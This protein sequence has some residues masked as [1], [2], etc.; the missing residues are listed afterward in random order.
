L[1]ASYESGENLNG[2][3]LLSDN[4]LLGFPGKKPGYIQ[5]IELSR[6]ENSNSAIIPAHNSA[7]SCLAMSPDGKLVASTS[8][9]GTLVRVFDCDSG[10]L[11]HELRRGADQA[12]IWT[13]N[14][15]HDSRKLCAGSDKGTIHIFNLDSSSAAKEDSSA[16]S[17][18]ATVPSTYAFTLSQTIN[19]LSQSIFYQRFFAKV[20]F[21]CME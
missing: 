7:L 21:V 12:E 18:K 2:L 11:L 4:G 5:L 13:L 20:L 10:T 14:F 9:K 6:T 3:L 15:S 8:I 17:V 1:V 16:V 19:P